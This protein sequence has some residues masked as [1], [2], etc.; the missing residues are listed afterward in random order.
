[1]TVT[2]NEEAFDRAEELITDGEFVSFAPWDASLDGI[3]T[4]SADA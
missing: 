3:S 4:K 2:L 1:M